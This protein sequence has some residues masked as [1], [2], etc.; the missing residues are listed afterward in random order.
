MSNLEETKKDVSTFEKRTIL[1]AFGGNTPPGTWVS[2][3]LYLQQQQQYLSAEESSKA[4]AQ[5]ICT[6]LAKSSPSPF[7]WKQRREE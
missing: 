1:Y 6:A 7:L 5:M 4:A 2:R 3:G